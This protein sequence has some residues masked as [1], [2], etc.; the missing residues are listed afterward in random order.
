M[1]KIG[2]S[3]FYGKMGSSIVQHCTQNKGECVISVGL[4][5]KESIGTAIDKIKRT[6][7]LDEFCESCDVIIDFSSPELL[8]EI[9]KVNTKHKKPL[10]SGTSG[11]S[12]EQINNLVELGKLTK[13]FWCLNMSEGVN[14]MRKLLTQATKSLTDS[15]IEILETHH[16]QKK[17]APSGTA[18][19]LG[20]EIAK[21]RNVNLGDV[22]KT[23]RNSV[24]SPSDIGFAVRRGGS[25]IGEHTVSF[26]FGDEVLEIT[27]K[28]FNRAIF[29]QGAVKA[30]VKLFNNP[31]QFGFFDYI[32]L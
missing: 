10:V 3:G 27:H 14:L 21:A 5:K 19:L 26:F 24:R 1:I 25:V 11:L 23:D 9:I 22:M 13:V 17:D 2:I 6:Y 18:L 4:D 20:N 7:D 31:A 12:V 28:A 8:Q 32:D 29:A 15:D 16:N 30:A